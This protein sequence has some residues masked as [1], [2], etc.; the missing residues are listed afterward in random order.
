MSPLIPGAATCPRLL[1]GPLR[2]AVEPA[3]LVAADS[4]NHNANHSANH[5]ANLAESCEKRLGS[6][7][8]FWVVKA[9]LLSVANWFGA[10]C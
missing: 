6:A 3:T 4:A 9:R 1:G 10:A 8:N 5:S 7:G 2:V